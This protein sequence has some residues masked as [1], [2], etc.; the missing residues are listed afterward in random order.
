MKPRMKNNN[1]ACSLL[2]AATI[3][4]SRTCSQISTVQV[5]S[6][7]PWCIIHFNFVKLKSSVLVVWDLI[8]MVLLG[9]YVKLMFIFFDYFYIWKDWFI[10]I[11]SFEFPKR[12]KT[13]LIVWN[14]VNLL[15]VLTDERNIFCTNFLKQNNLLV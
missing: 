8:F 5:R 14:P 9:P 4:G 15:R 1:V 2:L 3:H 11:K 12:K 13:T 10:K 7:L 6:D